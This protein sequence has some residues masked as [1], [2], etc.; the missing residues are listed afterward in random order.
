[1]RAEPRAGRTCLGCSEDVRPPALPST[2]RVAVRCASAYP[3]PKAG[4]TWVYL[5]ASEQKAGTLRV[6]TSGGPPPFTRWDRAPLPGRRLPLSVS[7]AYLPHSQD[8]KVGCS[9]RTLRCRARAAMDG[10]TPASAL[11]S[12]HRT[13]PSTPPW[14]VEQGCSTGQLPGTQAADLLTLLVL[15]PGHPPTYARWAPVAGLPAFRPV[16]PSRDR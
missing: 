8:W 11:L 7:R 15:A 16:S 6:C 1:M 9:L 12:S 10:A 2:L 3:R 14:R 13:E 4:W 5:G